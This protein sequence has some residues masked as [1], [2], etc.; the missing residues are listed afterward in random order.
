MEVL[1]NNASIYLLVVSIFCYLSSCN[2]INFNKN[3]KLTQYSIT[4]GFPIPGK[5]RIPA[6]LVKIDKIL[7]Y[8]SA[9]FVH[10]L[11]AGFCSLYKY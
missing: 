11:I 10:N 4:K 5:Y 8:K 2:Y 6:D 3:S 7:K 1:T 9:A